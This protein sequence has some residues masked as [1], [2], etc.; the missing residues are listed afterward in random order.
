MSGFFVEQRHCNPADICHGGWLST[1]ADVAMVRQAGRDGGRWVTAGLAVDFLRP[2]PLGSWIESDC[3][4]PSRGSRT[5][6]VQGV[7][8]TGGEPVLRMNATF[9]RVD[10]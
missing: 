7:A 2:V 3:A 4:V 1:F 10:S 9:R 6:I 8:R 5:C